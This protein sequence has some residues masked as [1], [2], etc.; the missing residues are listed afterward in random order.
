MEGRPAYLGFKSDAY[1]HCHDLPPQ[2]GGCVMH[3]DGEPFAAA[4]DGRDPS[5]WRLPLEPLGAGGLEPHIPGSDPQVDA[6][7]AGARIVQNRERVVP[8]ALR[9]VGSPGTRPV[10]APLSDPT[11]VPGMQHEAEA[12]AVLRHVAHA[13]LLGGPEDK[14]ARVEAALTPVAAPS[15]GLPG[16]AAVLS[17]AHL[18]DHVCVPRDLPLPAART[19]RAYCNWAIDV[20]TGGGSRA[21]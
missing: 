15:A 10:S 3:P 21:V 2:L 8:F 1:T 16:G 14:Q 5:S 12:D 11:A 7:L 13:L 6:L 20:L 4:I 9:G 18:R 17:L 19:L